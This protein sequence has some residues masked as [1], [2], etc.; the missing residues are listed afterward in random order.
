MSDLNSIDY[1]RLREQRER[2]LASNAVSPGI[3]AIHL[4]MATRYAQ[5]ISVSAADTNR[6]ARNGRD[7]LARCADVMTTT[8]SRLPYP[9]PRLLMM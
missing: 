4:D 8:Q 3:A 7:A 5:L 9:K 1:Y 2:D 6:Q